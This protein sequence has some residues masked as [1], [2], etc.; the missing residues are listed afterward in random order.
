MEWTIHIPSW[1]SLFFAAAGLTYTIVSN[2]S[3]AVKA[4]VDRDRSEA[5][6]KHTALAVK[7]DQLED[8]VGR[9]EGELRHMPDKDATHSLEKSIVQLQG[10]LN[11]M[12]EQLKPVAAMAARMQEYLIEQGSRAA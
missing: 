11:A 5:G 12:S 6:N 1:I 7:V 8:R 3:R 4:E 2:R 10:Q 9:I